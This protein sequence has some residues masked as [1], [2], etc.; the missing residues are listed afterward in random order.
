MYFLSHANSRE[1]CVS[2]LSALAVKFLMRHRITLQKI[3]DLPDRESAQIG[4]EG[5][6]SENAVFKVL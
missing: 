4:T 5:V 3:D 1:D 2:I 6:V